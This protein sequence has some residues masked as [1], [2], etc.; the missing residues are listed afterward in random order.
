MNHKNKD[1]LIFFGIYSLLVISA[2]GSMAGT[3][4]WY[5]YSSRASAN[6]RG[7]AIKNAS[8]L[9][10]GVVSTVDLPEASSHG[11]TKDTQNPN[12][13]WS[14]EGLS[15]DTLGYFLRANGYATN[16]LVPTTSGSYG[17]NDEFKIKTHPAELDN[18]LNDA[19][20]SDYTYLPLVFRVNHAFEDIDTFDVKLTDSVITGNGTLKE[21][22]RINFSGSGHNFIFAPNTKEAGFTT[23]G[24]ALD[25]N[26]DGYR[27]YSNIG[28][29]E[30]PYGEWDNLVYKS[31]ATQSDSPLPKEQRTTFN[32][33]SK[34]GIYA[35]DEENSTFK[36]AEYLGR[37]D[38]LSQ[39]YVASADTSTG[40]L[41]YCNVTIYLEGWSLSTIDEEMNNY[42]NLDLQ[43][44][45]FND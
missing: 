43:F 21:S 31:E 26:M 35:I 41:A 12:I 24:G 6:F 39:M 45:L 11:L 37:D 14:N 3:Y 32:G 42:F 25:L 29:K 13:Y 16:M 15:S 7:T 44:E 9:E 27:D 40:G 1:R 38:V 8:K 28:N 18:S 19:K 4:A 30:F 33:V 2:V 10:M 5:E 34:A 17:T 36:T 20:K 22:A 23:V